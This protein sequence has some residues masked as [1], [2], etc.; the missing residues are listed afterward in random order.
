MKTILSVCAVIA[1]S[2]GAMSVIVKFIKPYRELKKKVTEHDQ[3]LNNNKKELD[4]RK[5][6]DKVILQTQFAML[7]HMITNN[8]IEKLKSTRKELE[9]YLTSH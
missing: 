9:K 4:E 2:G 6:A 7:D 3:Y 1:A 5:E 8:S